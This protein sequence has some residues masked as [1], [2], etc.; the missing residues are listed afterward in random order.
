MDRDALWPLIFGGLG[1][2]IG[3]QATC[4]LVRFL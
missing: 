1:F 3:V 2:V 4:L